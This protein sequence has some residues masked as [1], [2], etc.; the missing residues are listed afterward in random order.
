VQANWE[1]SLRSVKQEMRG[2]LAGIETE[3]Q[4]QLA[5]VKAMIEKLF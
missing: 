4:E 5:K 1:D 3:N 2:E